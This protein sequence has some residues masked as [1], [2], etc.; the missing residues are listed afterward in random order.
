LPSLLSSGNV[1]VLF[2]LDGTLTDPRE[3][4]VA[5]MRFAFEGIGATAPPDAVLER[6]IGPPL[7]DTFAAH[8]P[9]PT[10]ARIDRAIALYRERFSATGWRENAVYPHVPQLLSALPARGLPAGVATSKPSV[11]AERIT[12]HFD[13]RRHFTAVYGSELDGTRGTKPELLAHVLAI[14][15]AAPERTVMVGDRHHDVEGARA[16]GARA[17]AV[18]WGY[19]SREELARAGADWICDSAPDVLAAL[20]E[21][22]AGIR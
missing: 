9:E 12:R 4:I 22:M 2:D 14:E 1:L 20:D 18:T 10:R 13:L 6:E 15:G 19:G 17:I 11:F 5:S 21:A 3:G 7:A 16:V 8:L